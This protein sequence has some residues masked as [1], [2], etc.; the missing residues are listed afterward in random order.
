MIYFL[1]TGDVKAIEKALD[2]FPVEG[3]TTN[4]TIIAKQ[5]KNVIET[6]KDIRSCIGDDLKL[7]VQTLGEHAEDIVREAGILRD[8]VKGDFY[9]KI[10]VTAEGIKAMQKLKK[11][12]FQVTATAIFTQQQALIAARAGA[13]YVAPYVNRLDNISSSGI[14]VVEDIV[15]L[16]DRY[17]LDTQVLAASFKNVEQVH[18][19]SLSG[20][21]SVTIDP[22]LYEKLLYHPLTQESVIDF[23]VDGHTYYNL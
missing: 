6:I 23:I 2:L 16:I 17:D 21:H 18:Q 22:E 7:H 13:D 11:E 3:V 12:G 10:P 1:D 5:K 15:T 20:A 4:P 14:K 19:V 9:A 8:A